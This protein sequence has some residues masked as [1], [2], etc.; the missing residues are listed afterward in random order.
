VAD[1]TDT[2]INAKDAPVASD[3]VAA[4]PAEASNVEA[5]GE[6]KAERTFSISIAISATRCTL[7]Y[8]LIPWIFPF[9]GATTGVGPIVGVIVGVAAIVANVFSI[10]R[11]HRADHRWKWQ[12]TVINSLVIALVTYLVVLDFADLF[13]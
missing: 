8:V 12:M 5:N 1:V 10:R 3:H 7:T 9:L 6:A 4:D 13:G 2:A 11:F